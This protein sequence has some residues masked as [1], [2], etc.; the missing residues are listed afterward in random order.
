MEPEQSNP[1]T[2]PQVR[3]VQPGEYLPLPL[4]FCS[5]GQPIKYRSDL[6]Y[7]AAWALKRIARKIKGLFSKPS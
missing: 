5:P 7:W 1:S 2:P 3:I 6:K 4:I